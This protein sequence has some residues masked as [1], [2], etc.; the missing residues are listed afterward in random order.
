MNG[1]DSKEEKKGKTKQNKKH[2]TKEPLN[3]TVIERLSSVQGLK[4]C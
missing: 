2:I 3:G 4:L 1:M